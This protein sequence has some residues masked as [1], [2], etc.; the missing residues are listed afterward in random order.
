MGKQRVF[1]ACATVFAFVL[2]IPRLASAQVPT[3]DYS[4]S[5]FAGAPIPFDTDIRFTDPTIL[6]DLT[7]HDAELKTS[8]SFGGKISGWWTGAR[9]GTGLDFGAELDVTQFFPDVKARTLSV[10]GTILNTIRVLQRWAYG[11]R[12]EE[13]LTLKIVAAFLHPLTRS[14][15]KDPL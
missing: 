7:F 13:Y 2:A 9:P 1:L 6:T 11:Y 8:V 12:D 14:A 3:W 10:T 5:A 15:Q 4:V